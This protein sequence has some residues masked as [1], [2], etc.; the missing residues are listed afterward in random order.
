VIEG[1]IG[2]L[3]AII[4]VGIVA[5]LIMYLIDMIP[6]DGRFKQIAKVLLLLIAVLIILARALPLLGISAI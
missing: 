1:L 2:L 3:I 4:V 6:I 5:A